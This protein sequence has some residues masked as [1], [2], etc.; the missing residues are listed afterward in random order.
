M[1]LSSPLLQRK[2]GDYSKLECVEFK[3]KLENFVSSTILNGK[4]IKLYANKILL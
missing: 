2:W 4:E 1:N 3:H